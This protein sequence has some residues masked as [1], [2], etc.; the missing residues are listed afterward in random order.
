MHAVAA[1]LCPSCHAPVGQSHA[2][3][4]REFPGVVG[5]IRQPK[6]PVV[7]LPVEALE[8]LARL[9][10]YLSGGHYEPRTS[11]EGELAGQLLKLLDTVA[12]PVLC[13][14]LKTGNLY[15]YLGLGLDCTNSRNG[16]LVA[17]YIH[18]DKPQ[19][20]PPYQR[21]LAEFR[22]KFQLADGTAWPDV[23]VCA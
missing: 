7:A 15:W 1:N 5:T 6:V 20:N 3:G 14:H 10:S 2:P 13:R 9:A 12:H 11:E 8:V 4:C 23:E 19:T 22:E 21:E 16:T 18:A 17:R